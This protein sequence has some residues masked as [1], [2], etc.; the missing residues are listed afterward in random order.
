MVPL[1]ETKVL[2]LSVLAANQI[3]ARTSLAKALSDLKRT[4][5]ELLAA[6]IEHSRELRLNSDQWFD[7]LSK[8][9]QRILRDDLRIMSK[10]SENQKNRLPP[11]LFT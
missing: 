6:I 10:L 3:E 5:P 1:S 2:V 4:E 7:L 9:P 11:V 8:L